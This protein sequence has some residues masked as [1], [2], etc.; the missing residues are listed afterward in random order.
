[1]RWISRLLGTASDHFSP[2]T[3]EELNAAGEALSQVLGENFTPQELSL[4]NQVTAALTDLR[5][6]F[7][8]RNDKI[9]SIKTLNEER[10]ALYE[11][12]K[13]LKQTRARYDPKIQTAGAEKRELEATLIGDLNKLGTKLRRCDRTNKPLSKR[14]RAIL[15]PIIM[16]LGEELHVAKDVMKILLGK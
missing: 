16:K 6:H 1:M 5:T 10:D 15:N 3:L 13:N 7:V 8:E 11:Q 2:L 14:I 9:E 12:T 4:H